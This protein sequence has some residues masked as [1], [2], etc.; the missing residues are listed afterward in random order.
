MTEARSNVDS[1]AATSIGSNG[2]LADDR[3][4]GE[5]RSWRRFVRQALSDKAQV[6][7]HHRALCN[8]LSYEWF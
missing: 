2:S 3:K 4:K 8:L 6:L 1:D 7:L 5:R